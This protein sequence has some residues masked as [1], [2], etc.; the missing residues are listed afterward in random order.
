ME[1]IGL[2]LIFGGMIFWYKQGVA[3]IRAIT[4]HR[5]V[6][7]IYGVP[8]DS[9]NFDEFFESDI[10]MGSNNNRWNNRR[11]VDVLGDGEL[12]GSESSDKSY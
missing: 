9:G 11:L 4:S 6:R 1:Y 12:V 10:D 8:R 7:G 2:F 3:L 5:R